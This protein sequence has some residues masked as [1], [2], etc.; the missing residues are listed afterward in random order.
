LRACECSKAKKKFHNYFE[1]LS[2]CGASASC[3]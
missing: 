3:R 1:I 2:G